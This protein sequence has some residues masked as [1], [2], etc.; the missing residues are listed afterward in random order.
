MLFLHFPSFVLEILLSRLK[1]DE[2]L[3]ASETNLPVQGEGSFL[4][5]LKCQF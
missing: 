5:M 1:D 2:A 3:N 4:E